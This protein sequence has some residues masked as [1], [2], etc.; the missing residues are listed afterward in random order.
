M[1]W[2]IG[3]LLLIVG[4]IIGYF[5]AK[6][7]N[8]RN[9]LSEKDGANEQSLRDL[10]VQQAA[11][12]IQESKK[13]VLLLEQQTEALN[14][15][16]NSYEQLIVSANTNENETSMNYFGEHAAAYLRNNTSKQSKENKV[17]EFQPLDFSSQSS[18][19]FS[20]SKEK[21]AK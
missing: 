4:G 2:V 12:H 19:L 15:Q 21:K 3:I 20:G 10:M 9:K 11:K 17:T 8:E 6:F 13:S 1:D 7:V 16:I 5:V 18:G 14:Q